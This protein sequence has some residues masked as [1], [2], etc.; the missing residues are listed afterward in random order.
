[1]STNINIGPLHKNFLSSGAKDHPNF[2]IH[3]ASNFIPNMMKFIELVHVP[4]LVDIS[5]FAN[6][7]SE[8]VKNLIM[9]HG[10]DKHFHGYHV[11]YSYILQPDKELNILEIGM[12]TRNPEI[13]STMYF[14]EQ[15]KQFINT[16]GGSLRF[17]KEYCPLSS[18]HGADIDRDILFTEDRIQTSHVDQLDIDSLK[19]LFGDKMFDI[20]VD[21]GLHHISSNMNTLLEALSHINVDGYIVIEDIIIT[22][23]WHV[24]D[25]AVSRIPGFQTQLINLNTGSYI[26]L[27]KRIS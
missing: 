25:F 7:N 2:W 27:I 22:D 20:I 16:P 8:T 11:L 19:S 18:I 3:G 24:V 12:G 1:M 5:E 21:D 17:F 9:K 23:N 6:D 4:K 10:S 13:P 14:Y 15:D 26:Y